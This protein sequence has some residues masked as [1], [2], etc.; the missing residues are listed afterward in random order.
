VTWET[1]EGLGLADKPTRQRSGSTPF[2]KALAAAQVNDPLGPEIN[3]IDV[4]RAIE[5]FDQGDTRTPQEILNG[6]AASKYS[7]SF[8]STPNETPNPWCEKE[9]QDKAGRYSEAE[10]EER[11][12]IT[13]AFVDAGIRNSVTDRAH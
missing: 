11:D 6:L 5:Q 1:L 10:L 12:K 7:S 2:S 3:S 8:K 13:K 4:R 9:E